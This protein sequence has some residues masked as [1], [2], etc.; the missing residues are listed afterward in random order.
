MASCS[1]SNLGHLQVILE[2]NPIRPEGGFELI[3]GAFCVSVK[4]NFKSL[5][6]FYTI[7]ILQFPK[8]HFYRIPFL[9]IYITVHHMSR[10]ELWRCPDE[11]LEHGFA[12]RTKVQFK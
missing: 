9:Y 4:S 2:M 10:R 11:D 7:N 8:G 3:N 12:Q 6:P 5:I 1:S